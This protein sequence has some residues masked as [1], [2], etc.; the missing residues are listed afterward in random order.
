MIIHD[1]N[2]LETRVYLFMHKINSLDDNLF[3]Y[4]VEVR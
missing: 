3:R 1:W 2:V 4:S